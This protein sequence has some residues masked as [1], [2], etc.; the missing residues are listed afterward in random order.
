MVIVATALERREKE[1]QPIRVGFVGAGY[2]GR[3]VALQLLKPA[4]GM[5]LA[6]IYNRTA[7]KAEHTL[8]EAGLSNVR[9][10]APLAPLIEAA[11]RGEVSTAYIRLLLCGARNIDVVIDF[12]SAIDSVALVVF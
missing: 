11:F 6:A 8:P 2:M 12:P 7:C 5:R 9:K 3:A 10:I 4:V 1:G